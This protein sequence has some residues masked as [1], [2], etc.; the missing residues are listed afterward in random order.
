MSTVDYDEFDDYDDVA[1]KLE[2]GRPRRKRK[3]GLSSNAKW[4][5]ALVIEL[6]LI[7]LLGYG[8]FR[9]FLHQK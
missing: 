6:I 9:S 1:G 2:E 5:I 7:M 4:G 3:K 8:L